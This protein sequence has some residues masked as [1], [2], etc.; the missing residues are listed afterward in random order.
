MELHA[1]LNKN[2]VAIG[3]DCDTKLELIDYA[4]SLIYQSI[5]NKHELSEQQIRHALYGRDR[6]ITTGIGNRIALPHARISSVSSL[7]LVLGTVARPI[8]FDSVD[9]EPIDLFACLLIPES[10]SAM[11]LK[12]MAQI[13]QFFMTCGDQIRACSTSDELL[14]LFSTVDVVRS[15]I[16]ES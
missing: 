16:N 13:M 15:T 8:P 6:E 1:Y 10:Q 9:G 4:A 14:Q 2:C 3:V 12:V 5:L 11:G 7:H